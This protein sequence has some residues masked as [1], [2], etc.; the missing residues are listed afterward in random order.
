MAISNLN[1]NN[2]AAMVERTH[3]RNS[4]IS[5]QSIRLKFDGN[6]NTAKRCKKGGLL[7]GGT[8]CATVWG[9]DMS[10]NDNN[11]QIFPYIIYGG[12]GYRRSR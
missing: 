4:G 2:R 12:F 1:K 7:H 6:Y 10:H 3:K 5:R 11:Y 9:V 8:L